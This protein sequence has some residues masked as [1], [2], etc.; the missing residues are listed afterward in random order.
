MGLFLRSQKMPTKLLQ[1]LSPKVDHVVKRLAKED[2]HKDDH[3]GH[4]SSPLLINAEEP[5]MED[6]EEELGEDTRLELFTDAALGIICTIFVL[7]I[8]EML[9]D[10]EQPQVHSL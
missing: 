1:L 2:L 5:S 4:E 6:L 3:G 7:P 8:M 9:K 10:G